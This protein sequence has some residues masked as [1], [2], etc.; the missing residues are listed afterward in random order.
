MQSFQNALKF[1]TKAEMFRNAA[2]SYEKL[3]TEVRFKL[4]RHNDKYFTDKLKKLSAI[5]NNC[6][7]FPPNLLLISIIDF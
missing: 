6:K 4:T 5:Q 1:N 2:E 7:Y 3:I